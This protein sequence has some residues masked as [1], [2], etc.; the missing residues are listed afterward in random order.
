MGLGV[1][2]MKKQNNEGRGNHDESLSVEETEV[3]RRW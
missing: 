3:V 1:R 2:E